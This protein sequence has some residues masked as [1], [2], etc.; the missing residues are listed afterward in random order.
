MG[1]VAPAVSCWI[2]PK[3]KPCQQYLQ[4]LREGYVGYPG[5][6]TQPKNRRLRRCSQILFCDNNAV[7]E[8][9]YPPSG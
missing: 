2:S 6:L 1:M 9:L 4:A 8:I 5:F 7:R 3:V